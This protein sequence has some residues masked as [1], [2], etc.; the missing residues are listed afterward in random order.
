MYEWLNNDENVLM[1]EW[2]DFG[3]NYGMIGYTVSDGSDIPMFAFVDFHSLPLDPASEAFVGDLIF[4]NSSHY[5]FLPLTYSNNR[6][7]F[8]NTSIAS[9]SWI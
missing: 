9:L 8:I 2:N 6:P 5:H 1:D 7:F 3:K 4:K